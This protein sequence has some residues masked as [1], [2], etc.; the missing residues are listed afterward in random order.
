MINESKREFN[1]RR[2][3]NYEHNDQVSTDMPPKTPLIISLSSPLGSQ[4]N[5]LKFQF[6]QPIASPELPLN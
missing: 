1:Q 5:L 2:L 4:L 3:L 6:N